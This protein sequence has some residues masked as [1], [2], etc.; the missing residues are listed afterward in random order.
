MTAQRKL[1]A[2]LSA[3]I[4]GYAGLMEVEEEATY[5]RVK[6]L[7]SDVVRP[8]VA[9]HRGHIVKTTGDGF[10]AVFDNSVDATG[11]AVEIQEALAR[12]NTEPSTPFVMFRMGVNLTD[13]IIDAE[14]IFGDGVNLAARLQS[15]SEPGGIVVSAAVAEKLQALPE[16]KLVDLGELKL[17]NMRRPV[18][19]FSV[20]VK[21]G[22]AGH[23]IPLASLPDDRPSIA[24]LPFSLELDDTRDTWFADGIIE[25]IIHTLSGIGD[26]YVISRGTCLAYAH[27]TYDPRA[28]GRDLGVRYV[29]SGVV[30]R[31]NDRL[32]IFTE[33]VDAATGSVLHSDR[34]DGGI[35]DL[36]EMQDR[37]ATQVVAAIAPAVREHELKRAMRK[38]PDSVTAYDLLLQALAVLYQLRRPTFDRARGLLQ[39]AMA[40]DPNYAPAYSHAATWHMFRI[41]QGWSTNVEDDAAEAERCATAALERDD[42]DAVALAIHGQMLSFTRRDYNAATLFLDRAISA[43]PSCQM[44]WTLSSTT[45]GWIGDGER[46]V[47]HATRALQLSPRDPFAFFAEH[48]LSQGHYISGDFEQAVAWGRRA[49]ARNGMLTSNLRTLAGALVA[50]GDIEGA[51]EIARRILL[52]DPHFRLGNF[53]ARSA[54]SPKIL[55]LHVPRLRMAGLPD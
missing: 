13:A 23:A 16:F 8:S 15:S 5:T 41:G 35:G 3:D 52:A 19:A 29:M 47:R 18:T 33:V 46:A 45:A 27:R 28:V 32:R 44:A 55:E 42:N 1:V 39:Q 9:R 34:Y 49:A 20:K 50:S 11:C 7:I 31:A 14:D 24:V 36:F 25:G 30:H 22:L 51:R 17:K 53:A 6:T 12:S 21:D 43:G 2:V 48:M 10:L 26:L 38:P 54:M 4:A 37:I 40:S